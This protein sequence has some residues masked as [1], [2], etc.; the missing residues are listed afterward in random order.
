MPRKPKKYSYLGIVNFIADHSNYGCKIPISIFI[1][2]VTKKI[3]YFR[4]IYQNIIET[5]YKYMVFISKNVYI[6]K[7][8]ESVKENNNTI[9]ESIKKAD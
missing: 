3:N 7:V 9:H 4:T 2:H 1:Q 8:S 6:Y 5:F